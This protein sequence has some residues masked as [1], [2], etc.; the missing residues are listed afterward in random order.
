MIALFGRVAVL[1][2]TY[3]LILLGPFGFYLGG[4]FLLLLGIHLGWMYIDEI[5]NRP[6]IKYG[7][8]WK[9]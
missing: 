1:L 3:V 6:H 5:D 8:K 2:C 9:L 4:L 7:R